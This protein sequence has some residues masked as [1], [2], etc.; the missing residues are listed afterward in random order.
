MSDDRLD[1]DAIEARANDAAP[2][3]WTVGG[4]GS[5]WE[6]AVLSAEDD[7][8]C[9]ALVDSDLRFIAA[10][11][12]DVLVLVAEVRALRVQL[13][14]RDEWREQ[15][16]FVME[17]LRRGKQKAEADVADL[18]VQQDAARAALDDLIPYVDTY[19]HQQAHQ[20]AVEAL[21][22]VPRDTTEPAP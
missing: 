9:E 19:A 17:T 7:I 8:V 15:Q 16:S 5:P 13:A 18:R 14:E 6:G 20:R 10:A 3:S 22:S 12:S 1:L 4:V 2:G 11:R 21:G